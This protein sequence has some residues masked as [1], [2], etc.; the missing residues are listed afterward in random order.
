M[1]AGRRIA[2]WGKCIGLALSLLSGA[3]PAYA[4]PRFPVDTVLFVCEHG[5]VKSLVAKLEFER[6]ARAEGLSAVAI[7]RGSAADAAVPPWMRQALAGDGISLG[8]WQPRQLTARDVAD[9]Q[10]IVSFDLGPGTLP[11]GAA[12]RLAWDGLP[13]LSQDYA[14]GRTAIH[15]KV[16]HLVDSLRLAAGTNKAPRQ[17]SRRSP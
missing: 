13:A 4:Q 2:Y 14:A 6:L 5:T 17:P 10:L 16:R 9:A 11:A 12:T 15:I 8:D 7:S 3:L 1:R